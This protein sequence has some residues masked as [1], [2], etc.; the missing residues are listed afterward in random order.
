MVRGCPR[1]D[2]KASMTVRFQRKH[3]PGER[4]ADHPSKHS[5]R[6]TPGFLRWRT[7]VIQRIPGTVAAGWR[8]RF[9]GGSLL[10]RWAAVLGLVASSAGCILTKD[11]PDPALDVP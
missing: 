2:R 7:G 10:G 9:P 5:S 4:V 1:R 11:L 6:A 3:H 8:S